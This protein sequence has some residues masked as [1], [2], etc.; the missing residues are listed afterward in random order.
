MTTL[1]IVQLP[2]LMRSNLKVLKAFEGFCVCEEVVKGSGTLCSCGVRLCSA[3]CHDGPDHRA[4]H[5]LMLACANSVLRGDSLARPVLKSPLSSAPHMLHYLCLLADIDSSTDR[6]EILMQLVSQYLKKAKPRVAWAWLLQAAPTPTTGQDDWMHTRV[7]LDLGLHTWSA[8]EFDDAAEHFEYLAAEKRSQESDHFLLYVIYATQAAL[9]TTRPTVDAT[10]VENM[11]NLLMN[12]KVDA[13]RRSAYG[14]ELV[15]DVLTLSMLK[16]RI[17]LR[18]G[19]AV[20][21]T[22]GAWRRKLKQLAQRSMFLLSCSLD[23]LSHLRADAM[24]ADSSLC[25]SA[26]M[27]R[28]FS[29]LQRRP[30]GF[31]VL[32]ALQALGASALS[33]ELRA[34][35]TVIGALKH[36]AVA[37]FTGRPKT[38]E[39]A[40]DADDRFDEAS[41]VLVDVFALLLNLLNARRSLLKLT[42][43]PAWLARLRAIVDDGPATVFHPHYDCG[44]FVPINAVPQS[45]RL[46]RL[47][48]GEGVARFD[49]MSFL[50][51]ALKS[52]FE[53]LKRC[54]KA[55][56]PVAWSTDD[57]LASSDAPSREAVRAANTPAARESLLGD[58]AR[59]LVADSSL[60]HSLSA[61]TRCHLF[62]HSFESNDEL[63][64]CAVAWHR[65]AGD[66]LRGGAVA[67]SLARVLM[68][69]VRRVLRLRAG[70]STLSC[71]EHR[72]VDETTALDVLRAQSLQL[73]AARGGDAL[74]RH[75][76][77]MT[78]HAAL[79]RCWVELTHAFRLFVTHVRTFCPV[80]R[81]QRA[82]LEVQFPRVADAAA[83]RDAVLEQI[84]TTEQGLAQWPDRASLPQLLAT[85]EAEQNFSLGDCGWLDQLHAVV[86]STN[87]SI[88]VAMLSKWWSH[89]CSVDE[90]VP[91]FIPGNPRQVVG[92]LAFLELCTEGVS[93]L[94]AA[95]K[96]KAK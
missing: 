42:P 85:I 4:F 47:L 41:R 14:S 6:K 40:V 1:D 5:S 94:V 61:W 79:R 3:A 33:E 56:Q 68:W 34:Q 81:T 92:G 54:G 20:G 55:D 39:A 95:L 15:L 96:V 57:W 66:L 62:A 46:H 9:C 64:A 48:G 88:D 28:V 58:C 76:I 31:D 21:P 25:A 27:L 26:R 32:A 19:A 71:M 80:S 13:R 2:A 59:A 43:E 50:D 7:R 78:L 18:N 51:E 12:T 11:S 73:L 10:D 67:E 8:G 60:T 17:A 82:F 84:G 89:C 45:S 37:R 75:E 35:L 70:T 30:K 65:L 22:I 49:V 23:A 63:L 38:I 36:F 24:F 44:Y 16:T 29:D 74:L 86:Q 93:V 72:H 83:L 69:R 91:L 87:Q 77:S 52:A 90:I 53:L